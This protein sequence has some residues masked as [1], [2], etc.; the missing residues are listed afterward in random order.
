MKAIVPKQTSNETPV[1]SRSGLWH[2]LLRNIR[3]PKLKVFVQF[4]FTGSGLVGK[5]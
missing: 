5:Q 2:K 3:K 4:G 1:P